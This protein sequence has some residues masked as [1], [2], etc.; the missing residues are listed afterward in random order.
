MR[1]FISSQAINYPEKKKKISGQDFSTLVEFHEI[2]F[3]ILNEKQINFDK[4][5]HLVPTSDAW[6]NKFLR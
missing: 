4:I 6:D 2:K 3:W 5:T 1:L